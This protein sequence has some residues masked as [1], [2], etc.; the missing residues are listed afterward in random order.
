MST[1]NYETA[2]AKFSN[3]KKSSK[4]YFPMRV[5]TNT[6]NRQMQDELDLRPGDKINVITD[7]GEYNDGWYFGKNLS[8][9]KTGL[10]PS[11]FTQ[12]M[13][14]ID[15]I[16]KT[17]SHQMN[18]HTINSGSSDFNRINNI[19]SKSKSNNYNSKRVP[20]TTMNDIDQASHSLKNEYLDIFEDFSSLSTGNSETITSLTDTSFPR[21][22]NTFKFPLNTNPVKGPS[23]FPILNLDD[24]YNQMADSNF[25]NKD[26]TFDVHNLQQWPPN[27]IACYFIKKGIDSKTALLFE[28]HKINGSILLELELL[29]LK[30][31]DIVSFGTR[32]TVFKIIEDLKR[33]FKKDFNNNSSNKNNFISPISG[34]TTSNNKNNNNNNYNNKSIITNINNG[35]LPAPSIPRFSNNTKSREKLPNNRQV[36]KPIPYNGEASS[37]SKNNQT[38][39]VTSENL[40][41]LAISSNK[42]LFD[43]PGIAHKPPS[44]PS[45]VQP[46]LSPTLNRNT[47]LSPLIDK[48]SF[49]REKY[50]SNC[51]PLIKIDNSHLRTN[52][53]YKFGY[54]QQ[55]MDSN[56]IP[57]NE[58]LLPASSSA[59][60]TRSSNKNANSSSFSIPSADSPIS[61]SRIPFLTTET[62]RSN[63]LGQPLANIYGNQ[64]TP[65]GTRNYSNHKKSF[66]GGSF[67]DLYN[68]ISSISPNR[69]DL[70]EDNKSPV[71]SET[72]DHST[73]D[74]LR[75]FSGIPYHKQKSSQN[76]L[77]I[78]KHRRTSSFLSFLSPNKVDNERMSNSNRQKTISHSTDPS[79]INTPSKQEIQESVGSNTDKTPK[80]KQYR[81]SNFECNSATSPNLATVTPKKQELSNTNNLSNSGERRVKSEIST[82]SKAKQILRFNGNDKKKTSAFVEGLR[83]ITV[84]EAIKDA[85][86][87]GWMYKKSSGAMGTWK[88]R[89]FTLHGTRLSY[90]GSLSDTRERGLIDITSHHV[91]SIKDEDRLITLSAT[92]TR[93]GRYIFKLLPPQPG[94]RK[95]LT[96][97]QPKV[98]YFS[99]DSKEDIRN[100]ISALIKANIDIDDTVPVISTYAMP[101]ISLNKAKQMLKEAKE[102]MALKLQEDNDTNDDEG[103]LNWE[104]KCE[105][106]RRLPS[107]VL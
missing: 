11:N 14:N 90:F 17:K 85:S 48:Y 7:D 87:Y 86:C 28:K 63:N 60:K 24:P 103:K 2:G 25:H 29:H 26:Y 95:G 96:F 1:S 62:G 93:N 58:S 68:R 98:H 89:F 15:S 67:I 79:L 32:F 82:S 23:S 22:E 66:S 3:V 104:E 76:L 39:K 43:S 5:V 64:T 44:Y 12:V 16:M 91:A 45:P 30:E 52:A 46:R 94:S 33:Q 41:S 35:L 57:E 99:V 36:T 34:F 59:Y 83:N 80:T 101:T 54:A 38:L 9:G 19:A 97:T 40:A 20:N 102:E 100:W 74:Q 77:D 31:L 75:L 10:F 4:K 50:E 13:D 56:N 37:V 49:P 6:Y 18:S 106:P 107:N 53:G 55:P 88:K 84:D 47:N 21:N 70:L 8:T 71:I 69:T 81:Y 72:P 61:S 27:E 105:S 92:S 73:Y 65:T 42:H 78:K 51:K